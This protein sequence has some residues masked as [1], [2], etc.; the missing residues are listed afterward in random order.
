V[1][2]NTIA[3]SLAI[4]TPADGRYALGA[5][6]TTGGRIEAVSDEEVVEGIELLA[7]TEGIFTEP[8]GGVTVA[9]LRKLARSGAI[10]PEHTTVAYITGMGLKAQEAVVKRLPETV[11]I[12]PTLRAFE[13][14]VLVP[15]S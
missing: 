10:D 8:A 5:V 6:R 13:S 7:R 12:K 2:A 3:H 11:R 15:A 14:A 1:R 4:G 9:V